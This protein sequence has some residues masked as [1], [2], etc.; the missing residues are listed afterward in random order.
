LVPPEVELITL[1]SLESG[2]GLLGNVPRNSVSTHYVVV[3]EFSLTLTGVWKHFTRHLPSND[4]TKLASL[5]LNR[6]DCYKFDY[7]P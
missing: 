6:Y 3:T 2:P 7:C 4:P 1:N 5:R